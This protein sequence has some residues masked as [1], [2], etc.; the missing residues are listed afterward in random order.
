[1]PEPTTPDTR[2]PALLKA[3]SAVELAPGIRRLLAPNAGLMTGPG[4]NTYLLGKKEIVVLD[5]GPAIDTHIRAIQRAAGAPIRWVLVTHT[6]ERAIA[7]ITV[8]IV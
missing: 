2:P 5:P 3:G 8:F 1:M 7:I 4:T 6:I